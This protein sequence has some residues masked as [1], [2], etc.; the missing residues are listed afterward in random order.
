MQDG[1]QRFGDLP[2]ARRQRTRHPLAPGRKIAPDFTALWNSRQTERH[3]LAADD[4]DALGLPRNDERIG[5]RDGEDEARARR[6]QI[7]EEATFFGSMDGAS[8]FVRGDAVAGI[9]IMLI[10]I[11][12][13]LAVGMAQHDLPLGK[14]LEVYTLLTIGDGLVAQ[15]PALI[16]STAAGIVVSRVGTD[17]DLSEQLLGQMFTRPQVLYLTAAVMGLIGVIPNMPHFAFLLIASALGGLAY[18]LDKNNR[19]RTAMAISPEQELEAQQQL[20]ETPLAEV[21]WKDVQ[22]VDPIGLEVG[23]RLIPLVDRAQDG[24][25]LRRVRGIRKKIAQ[26]LGFLVPSVHIRD[27]LEIRPNEYRILLKGVEVGQGEAFVGQYLAINPGRVL[28]RL[29]GTATT[30]PAFGLPATWI[31]G[32]TRDEAQTLG[33]TVVDAS[34]VVATH[35]NHLI[36]SHASELLGRID[37][38]QKARLLGE[39]LDEVGYAG[40]IGCEYKPAHGAVPGG[41][42]DGLGWFRKQLA[43][44]NA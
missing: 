7:T 2:V 16:I 10:N 32:A 37:A 1:A 30:D 38:D 14:A 39:V 28:G 40:W 13:G 21:S 41:T 24:E 18:T 36:L 17:K 29:Q 20:T 25:L 26:E 19:R 9:M 42:T 6:L 43:S 8:K 4:E 12:G 22:A 15:I 11:V 44:S 3:G 5:R 31:D 35:L 27:N 33:Y 23:Y 34:T